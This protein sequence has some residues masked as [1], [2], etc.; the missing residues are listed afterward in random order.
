MT[1]SSWE[2]PDWNDVVYDDLDEILYSDNDT[3]YITDD[4]INLEGING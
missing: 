3:T 2:D 4:E 1:I